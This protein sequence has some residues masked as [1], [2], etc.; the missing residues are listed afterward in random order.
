[1]VPRSPSARERVA[2]SPLSCAAGDPERSWKEAEMSKEKESQAGVD[3]TLMDGKW[4]FVYAAVKP[5]R[6][7]EIDESICGYVCDEVSQHPVTGFCV[8]PSSNSKFPLR[9]MTLKGS[10]LLTV[11]QASY[12]SVTFLKHFARS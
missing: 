8:E 2:S 4:R 6:L 5:G 7:D 11:G 3:T 12:L 9:M 1:M 10:I